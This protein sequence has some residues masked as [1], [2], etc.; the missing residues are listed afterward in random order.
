MAFR[1][2]HDA[3]TAPCAGYTGRYHHCGVDEFPL[4]PWVLDRART[5]GP[6]ALRSLEAVHLASAVGL[7]AT[8]LVTY[9]GRLA[10]AARGEGIDVLA[11]GS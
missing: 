8:Q 1:V 9:D 2:R 6:P 7:Q 5:I 10:D 4:R 11:P 3:T